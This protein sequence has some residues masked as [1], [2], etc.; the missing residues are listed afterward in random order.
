[1]SVSYCFLPI[2]FF[3]FHFSPFP[4]SVSLPFVLSFSRFVLLFLL[5]CFI[6]F[7]IFYSHSILRSF[8]LSSF[9]TLCLLSLHVFSFVLRLFS[10]I[11]FLSFFLSCVLSLSI[12]PHSR[13]PCL[14][15]S[16]SH[17]QLLVSLCLFAAHLSLSLSRSVSL[18][19]FLSLSLSLSLPLWWALSF[20]IVH[21]FSRIAFSLVFFLIFFF[22]LSLY[23]SQL[24]TPLSLL[25]PLSLYFFSP[26]V[27]SL[28][29]FLFWSFVLVT[30]LFV[31]SRFLSLFLSFLFFCFF[32]FFFCSLSLSLS[33]FLI[34]FLLSLSLT[35]SH[36]QSHSLSLSF[37][38]SSSFFLSFFLSF[39]LSLSLFLSLSVSPSLSILL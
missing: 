36:C 8:L 10:V 39:P 30:D 9:L 28:C 5:L 26:L 15:L 2:G 12:P 7:M 31:A 23:I 17:L 11:A 22:S 13:S 14:T 19:L 21:L 20:H 1:M 24:L 4:V 16:A 34:F 3:V 18:S 33:S 25:I 38:L 32:L 29:F 27:F 6:R 37:F 35:L